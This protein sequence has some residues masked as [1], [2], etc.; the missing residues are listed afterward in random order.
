MSPPGG[1][2]PFRRFA[3]PPP[4]GEARGGCPA[5]RLKGYRTPGE[6][7]PPGGDPRGDRPSWAFQ[8]GW[9]SGGEEI[10]IFP[11]RVSFLF[12]SFSLDKQRERI[13]S[14]AFTE[15]IC[16]PR[17]YRAGGGKPRPYELKERFRSIKTGRQGCR[18][19]R[20][21]RNA[22]HVRMPGHGLGVGP[23]GRRKP[24]QY[25]STYRPGLYSEHWA[26]SPAH[27][28]THFRTPNSEFRA[29]LFS[30]LRSTRMG[31]RIVSR[32]MAAAR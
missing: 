14:L 32:A 26:I 21:D 17:P 4:E 9:V 13:P 24:G 10:A 23:C 5:G 18:P 7:V 31:T 22:L 8:I 1:E 6:C 20:H 19:L 2:R 30:R 3:T 11:S 29:A 15:G 16:K 12:G 25:E 27:S 28:S